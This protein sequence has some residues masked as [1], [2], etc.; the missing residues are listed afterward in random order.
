[1]THLKGVSADD[2]R[3]I[4]AEVEGKWATQRVIVGLNYK[5]GLTQR[6]LAEMYGVTEKT[7]YNWLCRLDRLVDEPV[8]E[9]VYDSAR[10]GRPPKL[11]DTE[12]ERLEEVLLQSPAEANYD[13]PAW[14]P[15]LAQRYIAEA[16][17]VDYC[18]RQVRT[19][20]TEA[21]L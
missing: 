12:H 13:A 2:L 17:D 10:S 4:L 14:T 1:M 7:I 3:Q 20:M 11:T 18:I 5:S 15:V 19:L 6:R 8:E 9:V 21:G 16:F